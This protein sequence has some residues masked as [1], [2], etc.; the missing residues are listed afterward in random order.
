MGVLNSSIKVG[1]MELANRLVQAPMATWLSQSGTVTNDMINYYRE[2]AGKVGLIVLEYAY[3]SPEGRAGENQLS[4]ADDA[5][6]IGLK[7]LV[8]AIHEQG[9][10]HVFAQINH[11]GS[12][13]GYEVQGQQDIDRIVSKFAAAACRAKSVGFDGV[14]IHAAHGYLLNQ[15]YSPLTNHRTGKYGGD[16]LVGRTRLTAEVIQAVRKAVGTK[17]PL[18]VRFGACDYMPGGSTI[19]EAPGAAS[20]YEQCG[21]DMISVSGGLNGFTVKGD[22]RP[23]YFRELSSAIR[24]NVS[25]PVMVTGGIWTV[26]DAE[27]ILTNQAADMIGVGRPILRNPNFAEYLLH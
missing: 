9:T 1:N 6:I 24:Q 16:T 5:D 10:T 26:N 19:E 8:E 17:Y 23:G 7:R 27:E 14:E 22:N 13:G 4:I 3:I 21:V 25:V 20:L 18:S 11:A 12:A 15:F 2:R